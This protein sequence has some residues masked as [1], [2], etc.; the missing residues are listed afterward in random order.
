MAG[1]RGVRGGAVASEVVRAL[2]CQM[3]PIRTRGRRAVRCYA[4]H[5][6]CPPTHSPCQ[7]AAWGLAIHVP[8]TAMPP[9]ILESGEPVVARIRYEGRKE[10]E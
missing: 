5:H 9:A 2:C 1:G 10:A 3:M 7:P 8:T 4:V 6:P